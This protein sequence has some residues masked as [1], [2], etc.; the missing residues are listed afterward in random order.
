MNVTLIMNDVL[1]VGAK[2]DDC[3]AVVADQYWH[4]NG[5][6]Q[7]KWGSDQPTVTVNVTVMDGLVTKIEKPENVTVTVETV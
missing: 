2:C 6:K 5:N 4:R 3:V 1:L 7:D